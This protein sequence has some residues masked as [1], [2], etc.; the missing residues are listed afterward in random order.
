[1]T[2]G[3]KMVNWIKRL[4]SDRALDRQMLKAFGF[5]RR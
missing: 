3:A 1:V 5:E 2:K 4:M